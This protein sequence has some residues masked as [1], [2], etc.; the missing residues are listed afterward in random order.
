MKTKWI[1]LVFVSLALKSAPFQSVARAEDQK[2]V[3]FNRCTGGW[4]E[5]SALTDPTLLDRHATYWRYRVALPTDKRLELRISG[6]FPHARYSS[7][8]VYDQ[9]TL[10]PIDTIPDFSIVPDIG[11][12][13]PFLPGVNRSI[14]SRHYMVRA[15][16]GIDP[17]NKGKNQLSLPRGT[18]EDPKAI[19]LWYR[20]FLSDADDNMGSVALPEIE[21]FNADTGLPEACPK[22]KFVDF[23]LKQA[24]RNRPPSPYQGNVHFYALPGS[25]MYPNANN[26]YLGALFQFVG[27]PEVGVIRF[28]APT[29][30]KTRTSNEPF[31]GREDVRYWSFCLGGVTT[32]THSCIADEEMVIGRDGYVNLVIGPG[33]GS[34]GPD[35]FAAE[36]RA[37][38]LNFLGR[39]KLWISFVVFRTFL[40]REDF[41]GNT[42]KLKMWP[43]PENEEW[44]EDVEEIYS[45]RQQMGD[46]APDGRQCSMDE[47][48]KNYCGVPVSFPK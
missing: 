15:V 23:E 8:A 35:S 11:S 19:E 13:N 22:P 24:L 28:K 2:Q 38:G 3:P 30:P 16:Q 48:E 6:D 9:A 37:K 17:A 47:F 25:A 43:P 26:R 45:A 5:Y 20:I 31:S 12:A 21:S 36:V 34:D 27:G 1:R 18:E 46:S 7:F 42:M 14:T 29:F 10:G 4:S 41:I 33:D 39:G 32:A 40:P 44:P